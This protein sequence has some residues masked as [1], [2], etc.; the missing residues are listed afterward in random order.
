MQ[1][2]IAESLP[3]TSVMRLTNYCYNPK[4]WKLR[5]LLLLQYW[6]WY[7]IVSQGLCLCHKFN[8]R[9]I[10]ISTK[11]CTM[12]KYELSLSDYMIQ[13]W[14]SSC[15]IARRP[16]YEHQVSTASNYTTR[17][18]HLEY[19]YGSSQF[20]WCRRN[21]YLLLAAKQFVIPNIYIF[22]FTYGCL[23]HWTSL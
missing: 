13:C 15:S 19:D 1:R 6:K 3:F 23:W 17:N 2:I 8:Q 14:V 18:W 9:T 12:E 21:G 11:I 4:A 5:M 16:H 22:C 7:V 10:F 20:F